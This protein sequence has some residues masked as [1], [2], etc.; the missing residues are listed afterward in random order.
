[1][2]VNIYSKLTKETTAKKK[3]KKKKRVENEIKLRKDI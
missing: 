3:K 2:Q 1:M